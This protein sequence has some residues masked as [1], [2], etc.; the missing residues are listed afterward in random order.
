M[1][2]NIFFMSARDLFYHETA[3][4]MLHRVEYQGRAV[5]S[6]TRSLGTKHLDYHIWFAN[7]IG[8]AVVSASEID[9]PEHELKC[10]DL[11]KIE[12]I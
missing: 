4:L 2:K 12:S 7:G 6:V 9:L 10:I 11:G 1:E 5:R 8:S 3:I